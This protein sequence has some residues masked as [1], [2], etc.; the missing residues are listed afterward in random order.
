MS[1]RPELAA[2][3]PHRNHGLF[4][5]HYLN[6]TL[7]ERPDWRAL[8]EEARTAMEEVSRILAAYTPSTNEAQTERDLVRPVLETL[9]HDFEVQVALQ[10][11]DGTK[12]PDYVFYRNAAAL[13]ANKNRTLDEE[14]LSGRSFA[15]GDAKY[16]ERALDLPLKGKKT[17]DPFTNKNPSYQISFYIQHSGVEWGVLTNGRLWRLYNRDTAHKLDRFYEVDLQELVESGDERRFLYFYAFFRRASF[18]DGPLGVASIL[19]ASADYARGVGDSLKAQ[20]YEA[21]RH[22]AQGFLDYPD[23]R[24]D[25]EPESLHR[26]YDNSLI[27]LYRLLF[28]L[29]AEARELLP[30]RGSED[31]RESYSLHAIKHDV[32]TGRRLLPTSATLWP[33]LTQLFQI[34]NRGSPPLSVATFNGG[35]F[36]PAR[37][38][39]LENYTVGDAHLQAAVDMLSRVKGEFVDYRDLAERHLGTIYEGLLEFH[40]EA[41]DDGEAP[42]EAGPSWTV[43]LLNDSG[44]RKATGSYYTPDFVVKY[45]VE[46][47][48]GPVLRAAIED[49]ENDEA[50][51]EAVLALDV[52]DPA[53]GSGHFLVEATEYI[54]RFLV[55]LDVSPEEVPDTAEAEADAE[56]AY[57][58]R[59]VVQSCVY[60]VD[61]NPLAVDLAKLSL[62]LSTVARDRPLSFL[63]HHLRTGNSLV[64][65]RLSDLQF[66]K[67][68]KTKKVKSADESQLS[69]LSDDAFRQSMSVAVGSMW[70]IE[71]SPAASVEDVKQQEQLYERLRENLTRRYARLADL[72]TATRFGVEVDPTLWQPL[73]DYATSKNVATL[74]QFQ[75]WLDAAQEISTGQRFFHWE[76]E[77]PEVFFDR[78]GKPLGDEAGFDAVVGNPPYVRQEA[79][80]PVKPY[81]KE[82]YAETY[83]GVADLYVYFYQQGLRQ[84]R[85]GGR[86]SYIVTNKWLRAGYGE[87]LRGYFAKEDALVEIVDFGHAPIFPDA[88][89]FPCIVVLQKRGPETKD[90]EADSGA[91]GEVRVAAV[92]REELGGRDLDRTVEAHAHTV[93]RGRFG[94]EAWSLESSA[95]D[96]LMAKIRRNGVPLAEFTG[97]HPLV[98]IKTGLNEAF[99]ISTKTRN[100]LIQSHPALTE[101]IRPYLRGRDIKRWSPSWEEL[102]IILLRSSSDFSWP[103]SDRPLGEAE[104]SFQQTFPS[105][106]GHMQARKARLQKRSDQGRFWWEL[107]SC[108]YYE[109]FDTA[110]IFYQDLAFHS[111][112][113]IGKPKTIAEMTCFCLPTSDKWTLTVLN[114]PAMWAYM[115][116]NV[117]HGKDEVLRLKSI[118]TEK[119]PIAPP[120]D[121]ARAEAEE[122]VGRLVA[123][124]RAEQESR[125]DALDWLRVEYGVEKP[126]QKLS[127]F[128]TLSGD[129]FVE[130]VR[131][132]RPKGSGRLSPAGLKELRAGYAE[133]ATPVREARAEAAKLEQR[134]SDLVNEAYD[135][136]PEE[137]DLLWSTAPPRM[138]QF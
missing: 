138:P 1:V 82:A 132:R 72:V 58:K 34:I 75:R 47:T 87:P 135:L 70:V 105:L 31:Y 13:A 97:V 52:L 28:V 92:P 50:K 7:P 59:R 38:P 117:I 126:G 61:M 100:G 12:V 124:T 134:L 81:F 122:A 115:W 85:S 41:L 62:W 108:A 2:D 29:Y 71:E 55:E 119:L 8:A 4:S 111:R 83:H 120:T 67:K 26:I 94:K 46:E 3:Q 98:G 78:H 106:H 128:A 65:A 54:A 102:W 77:F 25:P 32:A 56:L 48:V 19:R 35:L 6:V 68:R 110:N 73:A 130:E 99:L 74:P 112:F 79:L 63:D 137:V 51:V 127:D 107:R 131:K 109:A 95:V 104:K 84:L 60:G 133:L 30:V 125:R 116:R 89:V 37:H 121:E 96:D 86:M 10:T 21:L 33:R 23:N 123:F 22:I 49:A 5:D 66:G 9:G 136:T 43:A 64:G 53:M 91:N 44:E 103:W 17:G 129:E 14:T 18:D 11:P 15:V 76:L 114:S 45:I 36:D 57:W 42:E 27:L 40:L 16:W 113:G 90:A 80:G 88:D 69:M 20:V 24:L 39:F 101:H 93:P 118:Y